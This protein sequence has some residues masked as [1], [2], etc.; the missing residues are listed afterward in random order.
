VQRL[1][2][3][4]L[5]AGNTVSRACDMADLGSGAVLLIGRLTRSKCFRFLTD[6]L[7]RRRLRGCATDAAASK[8]R[9][10]PEVPRQQTTRTVR[11]SSSVPNP[12]VSAFVKPGRWA[13]GQA[14]FRA[15]NSA[16]GKRAG[17]NVRAIATA[18]SPMA[19]E[20]I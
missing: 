13:K 14:C 8:L 15:S 5:F 1:T 9:S 17:R 18:P 10:C 12:Q 20:A 2:A 4:Q 16:G 7:Q 19:A 6:L 3:L 11:R